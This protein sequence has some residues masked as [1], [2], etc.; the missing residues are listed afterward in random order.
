MDVQTDSF[1]HRTAICPACGT[2]MDLG[3]GQKQK[4]QPKQTTFQQGQPQVVQV[5]IPA[6]SW[7]T[8]NSSS[9]GC[10]GCLGTLAV[11]GGIG[12]ITIGIVFAV[13]FAQAGSLEE[14][15]E[16]VQNS[17]SSVF[18]PPEKLTIPDEIYTVST[19]NNV[20]S[21]AYTPDGEWLFA[22]TDEGEVV[23]WETT[24]Q[25]EVNR[26]VIDQYWDIESLAIS[27]NGSYLA[28]ADSNEVYVYNISDPR[29]EQL[30]WSNDNIGSVYDAEFTADNVYLLTA[31]SQD[32]VKVWNLE[33][34]AFVR[35][36]NSNGYTR[37][38]SV[39]SDSKY[40]ATV[41]SNDGLR[42]WDIETGE[43]FKNLSFSGLADYPLQ[44]SPDGEWLAALTNDEVYLFSTET[45]E[46]KEILTS[47]ETIFSPRAIAFSPDSKYLAAVEFF[48]VGVVWEVDSGQIEVFFEDIETGEDLVF[49]SDS[50]RVASIGGYYNDVTQDG[51][52]NQIRVWHVF[53]EESSE[54]TIDVTPTPSPTPAQ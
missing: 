26:W 47:S 22:G 52:G 1:G 25:S 54:D 29:N 4:T 48:R 46:R 36:M 8:Q 13:I 51:N 50:A 44:F 30:V 34:G 12:V 40:V 24:D 16:D 31:H 45:W 28:V 6:T 23:V 14:A 9:G 33:T 15:W 37:H 53:D 5:N 27:A 18:S 19:G 2:T 39:S 38:I 49:S 35:E 41:Y 10:G 17:V 42:I 7:G 21:L 32:G 11:F 43:L 20:S 3:Q